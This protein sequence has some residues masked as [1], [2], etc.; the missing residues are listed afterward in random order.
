MGD[1]RRL[2]IML[3]GGLGDCLLASAFVRHFDQ[4]GRYNQLICA[5]PA[6]AAQLYD[7]NP[8]VSKLVVCAGRDLWLWGLPEDGGDVFAPYARVRP[9]EG[10]NPNHKIALRVDRRLFKF[11]QGTEPAWRQLAA[12]HGIDLKDGS[13]E[14]VTCAADEAWAEEIVR[15]WQ[16]RKRILIS[17]RSPLAEKEYPLERWQVVVDALR[18]E[19]VVL[20]LGDSSL[21]KGTDLIHPLPGLRQSAALIRRCDCVLS[22]D[23]L[24]AHLAAAV[25]TP[26]VVLFGPTNPAVWGHPTTTCIRTSQC[27]VCADT[28]RLRQCAQRSCMDEIPARLVV[29]TVLKTLGE[30][31]PAGG[32]KRRVATL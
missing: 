29:E 3:S 4:S 5:L 15:Q 23:S 7:Y 11:N 26:A 27:P 25:G 13:P 31:T 17:Y 18:S 22:I 19:A 14:L 30:E 20:E 24:A 12:Y 6:R 16:G 10:A 28:P 2:T 1:K 9:I 21:L 8:R 32:S